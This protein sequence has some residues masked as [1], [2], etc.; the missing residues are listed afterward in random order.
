MLSS[1]A[2]SWSFF[3]AHGL[4]EREPWL[5]L[6]SCRFPQKELHKGK[7]LLGIVHWCYLQSRFPYPNY[8]SPCLH[9]RDAS[10][11]VQHRI[12]KWS[13]CGP[14][15]QQLLLCSAVKVEKTSL[16]Q[17]VRG[18]KM[19]SVQLTGPMTDLCIGEFKLSGCAEKMI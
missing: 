2:P 7:V 4:L 1:C 9:F 19:V 17:A 5:A 14:G 3:L 12:T 8:G 13:Q 15:C 10:G 11:E 18:G 6:D 16:V